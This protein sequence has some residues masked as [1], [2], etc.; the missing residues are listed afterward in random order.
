[1]PRAMTSAGAVPRLVRVSSW[2]ADEQE[3]GHLSLPSCEAQERRGLRAAEKEQRAIDSFW[4]LDRQ[5]IVQAEAATLLAD[6]DALSHAI[7]EEESVIESVKLLEQQ[8][9]DRDR[10]VAEHAEAAD[11][12]RRAAHIKVRVGD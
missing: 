8:C 11:R 4:G 12:Q 5:A 7:R 3:S 6:E 1:L 9:K 2:C 10:A